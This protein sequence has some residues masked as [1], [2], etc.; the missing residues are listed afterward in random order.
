ME[1]APPCRVPRDAGV[2]AHRQQAGDMCQVFTQHGSCELW[3]EKKVSQGRI[4]IV[5]GG[6]GPGPAQLKGKW[7]DRDR[8]GS[9]WVLLRSPYAVVWRL[10][11][12]RLVQLCA[13]LLVLLAFWGL[14]EKEQ[15]CGIL[16]ACC[17]SPHLLPG[18][19]RLSLTSPRDRLVFFATGWPQ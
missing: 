11:F 6:A 16:L 17:D 9:A 5:H 14:P 3:L 19:R 4:R 1:W 12:L 13:F 7:K 15:C 8:T 18:T 2:L 10:R